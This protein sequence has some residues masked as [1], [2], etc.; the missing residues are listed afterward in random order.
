M[1]RRPNYQLGWYIPNQVAALT[2]FHADVSAEDFMAVIQAA[3]DLL[4]HVD[5]EFHIIIDNRV[6]AMSAPATLAQ[7]KQMVPFMSHPRLRWVVVIKP[8]Q[9]PLDT[10]SLPIERDGATQLKNV[11]SLKE[12]LGHLGQATSAIHWHR[13]DEAFFHREE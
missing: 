4:Q 10:E 13:A 8:E 6:V 9:L 3:Q 11:S 12:A 2:H 7:M 1:M 5:N